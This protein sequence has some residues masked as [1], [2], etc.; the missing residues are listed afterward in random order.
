MQTLIKNPT[1]TRKS[2]A[3]QYCYS[4]HRSGDPPEL[5]IHNLSML[6]LSCPAVT[7]LSKNGS[8]RLRTYIR[9]C[10]RHA[11]AKYPTAALKKVAVQDVAEILVS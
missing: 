1:A 2:H 6:S 4:L 10:F 3:Y 8:Y 5:A 9:L 11:S 7:Y